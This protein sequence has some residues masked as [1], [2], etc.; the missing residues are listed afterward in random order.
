[1]SLFESF[2][3]TLGIQKMPW[4]IRVFLIL[5]LIFAGLLIFSV[6]RTP[7]NLVQN[8]DHPAVKLFAL[9]A[10]SMKIILGAL[11]GSLSLA[12]ERTWAKPSDEGTPAKSGR[13]VE[14][15]DKRKV[16]PKSKK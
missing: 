6:T 8:S 5:L 15:R 16:S 4:I 14:V 1:M 13:T 10:D 2:L 9:A 3:A 12:A 7:D 11:I